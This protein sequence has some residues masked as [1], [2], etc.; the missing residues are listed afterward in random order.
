MSTPWGV[1]GCGLDGD[2]TG[3]VGLIRDQEGEEGACRGPG[4]E[5]VGGDVA[6]VPCCIWHGTP[7]RV[8]RTGGIRLS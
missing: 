5:P 4:I 7:E 1:A 2:A 6:C 3:L 8:R